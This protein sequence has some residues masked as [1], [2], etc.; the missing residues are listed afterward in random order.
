LTR[1][2]HA[3]VRVEVDRT[4]LVIDP[5]MTPFGDARTALQDADVVLITHQHGDHLDPA[6][7]AE[8]CEADGDLVVF[9]PHDTVDLIYDAGGRATGVGPG[10]TL[11]ARGVAVRT[12][13]GE[14]AV[15]H[16]D[17][18]VPQNV[19]YLV[20]DVVYHPGD[21]LVVPDVDVRAVLVPAS[22]PWLRI[23]PALDYLRAARTERAFPIH[24]AMLSDI[25]IAGVDRW[26][27]LARDD[28]S[29]ERPHFGVPVDL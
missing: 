18:E 27:G 19:G 22:A 4:V 17:F 20:T 11:D 8:A 16:P 25:G 24:D 21:A 3:C 6:V 26:F 28:L 15:I 12:F 23:G 1:F 13:G 14:H 5:P 29:Y 9:A 2:G 10:Q 7:V